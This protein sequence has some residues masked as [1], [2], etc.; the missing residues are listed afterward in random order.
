M[1]APPN[2]NPAADVIYWLINETREALVQL[3][4]RYQSSAWEINHRD[5]SDATLLEFPISDGLFKER[6]TVAGD[7]NLFDGDRL[8]DEDA[9]TFL[10]KLYNEHRMSGRPL[11]ILL[12]P[13]EAAPHAAVFNK[14]IERVGLAGAK[15]TCFRD[16]LREASAVPLKHRAALVVSSCR[17]V[18]T[19]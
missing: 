1:N 7:Y 16:W 18:A 6:V 9:L 3:G 13:H 14:F 10:M 11:V 17:T 12:H 2:I 8:S 4:F 15:W 5:K 19:A